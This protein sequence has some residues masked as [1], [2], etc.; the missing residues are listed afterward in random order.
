MDI[1]IIGGTK[2]LG[3]HLVNAASDAGHRITLF[4]RGRTNPGLF[5]DIETINGDRTQ[6]GDLEKLQGRRRD[7]VIDTSGYLPRIVRMSA[8]ALVDAVDRYIFISS[9]SVYADFKTPGIDETYRVGT[10]EDETVEEITHETYGPLKA[11]CEDAV[12]QVMPGRG[13]HI[14]SGLIVGPNDP[15]DRFTYWPVRVEGGGQMVA[16]D[17]P[18]CPVQFIDVRDLSEWIIR[19][20]EARTTG[21]YNV[22]GP[23]K[24]YTL[25]HVL[26]SCK[27]V[28]DADTVVEWIDEQFLLDQEVAP[29]TGMPL[30]IPSSDENTVGMGRINIDKAQADGLI[31][32]DLKE[33]IRDTLDWVHQRSGDWEWRAGITREKEAKILAAWDDS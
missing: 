31:F 14:R 32:R 30:W 15:T 19:M 9:I 26:T 28:L 2:F 5:P 17:F 13:L 18:Q 6:E 20:A 27:E 21:V 23:E 12:D 10:L 3:R 24:P 29:W 11:L 25:E 4:N 22:T 8:R 33:T 16:P 1:L 7:A